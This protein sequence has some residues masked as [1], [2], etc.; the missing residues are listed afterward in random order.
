MLPILVLV[1]AYLV[2]GIPFGYLLGRARGVNLFRE[3]SGNIGATNVWRVLGAK[4]GVVCFLLDFAKGAAPVVAAGSLVPG[5]EVVRTGAA[6]LA[7]LGHLFP[8]YLGFRGGKGVATGAGTIAVLVP[9]PAAMAIVAWV[10]VF[11]VSRFV[12]LASIAAVVVLTLVRMLST[13]AWESGAVFA[14]G[15][16]LAGSLLVI[17]K[18]R[19]NLKRLAAGTEPPMGDWAMRQTVVRALHVLA[20]G[21]WF[22]GAGFFNFVVAPAIFESFQHVAAGGPSDRTAYVKITPP[23]EAEQKALGSALAGSAVGPVF[24]KYFAMQAGC[25]VIALVTALGW[26]KFGK[27]HRVRVL[28][29]AV[30]L[31]TV[32]VGWPISGEVS[33]LRLERFNPDPAVAA[34]ARADFGPWHLVS[35]GLSFVTVLTA[36]VAL[37]MAARLPESP[38]RLGAA[39][40]R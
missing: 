27:W 35:L 18:H 23:G 5:D 33:R 25:G 15:Y 19:S 12:S 9:V 29:L 13:G 8:I 31:V 6:A 37:A 14:T 3:G 17:V 4:F 32:A 10:V 38:T 20:L 1:G 30:G 22:G 39:S 28:V 2:G 11:L 21:I 34:A 16:C 7:F 40:E 36:G 24:P 26:W